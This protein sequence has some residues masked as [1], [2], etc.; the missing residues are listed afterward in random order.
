[1]TRPRLSRK[2]DYITPKREL[3]TDRMKCPQQLRGCLLYY[4]VLLVLCFYFSSYSN[5]LSIL[6]PLGPSAPLETAVL[7]SPNAPVVAR[8][9]TPGVYKIDRKKAFHRYE[10]LPDHKEVSTAAAEL[11][12]SEFVVAKDLDLKTIRVIDDIV[13]ECYDPATND[14]DYVLTD[15]DK[16]MLSLYASMLES[17]GDTLMTVDYSLGLLRDKNYENTM[18]MYSTNYGGTKYSKAFWV[19]L[20][21]ND[22]TRVHDHASSL[23]KLLA[24][25]ELS[26]HERAHNEVIGGHG[27]MFQMVYN[28]Q[29][30]RAVRNLDLYTSLG[31]NILNEEIDCTR[32]AEAETTIVLWVL[33]AVLVVG[34]I[35]Y[36][37]L[38]DQRGRNTLK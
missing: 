36:F 23:A 31:E 10:T 30:H 18:G 11:S 29:Y 13:V 27:D 33:L 8:M 35:A 22:G 16:R 1:M 17:C 2:K 14:C 9:T 25:L 6:E 3:P 28:T 5:A 32:R 26:V 20:H 4:Y 34:G 38:R 7:A 24:L 37:C 19:R 15:Y 12:S 21:W